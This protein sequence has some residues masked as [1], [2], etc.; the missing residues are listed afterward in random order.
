[1]MS[2]EKYILFAFLLI[3][4]IGCTNPP[5]DEISLESEISEQTEL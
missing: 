4:I 1:M 3:G 2:F 5:E